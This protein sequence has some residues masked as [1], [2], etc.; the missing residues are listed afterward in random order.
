MRAVSMAKD[1]AISARLPKC[2][3]TSSRNSSASGGVPQS[4]LGEAHGQHRLAGHRLE[5]ARYERDVALSESVG[6]AL[7]VVLETLAPAERVAFVLHD[8]FELPLAEIAPIVGRTTSSQVLSP[9]SA[10]RWLGSGRNTRGLFA[11][12][13]RVTARAAPMPSARHTIF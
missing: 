5:V 9:S 11:V 12:R 8:M 4:R 2:R 10:L 1:S 3:T 7:L 13:F 6:L